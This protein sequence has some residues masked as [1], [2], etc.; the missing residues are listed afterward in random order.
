MNSRTNVKGLTV[1]ELRRLLADPLIPDYL[2]IWL[3]DDHVYA[4]V[5]LVDDAPFDGQLALTFC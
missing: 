1:G 4:T 3:E 2:P 5:V